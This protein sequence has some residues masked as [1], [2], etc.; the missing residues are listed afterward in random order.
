MPNQDRHGSIRAL[1]CPPG[2]EY[3]EE[4]FLYLLAVERARAERSNHRLRLLLAMLEPVPGK[5]VPIPPA[6]AARLFKGLK[7]SLRDTDIVGWYR[8]DRVVGAVLSARADAP[9]DE[10]SGLIE[11]RVGEGL[12]KRLPSS[13]ARGLRVRVA[14]QGP[15]RVVKG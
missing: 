8:Q 12:R 14:E 13:V 10:T 9:G 11:Q 15:Q 2:T 4:T 5:P 1:E 7:M 6:R 3:D